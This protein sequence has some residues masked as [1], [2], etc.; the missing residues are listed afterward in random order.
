MEIPVGAAVFFCVDLSAAFFTGSAEEVFPAELAFAEDGVSE[1]TA[2]EIDVLLDTEL[3]KAASLLEVTVEGTAIK[4]RAEEEE[5][6]P[7]PKTY[8]ITERKT[9]TAVVITTA[10]THPR[11]L[12]PGFGDC[13]GVPKLLGGVALRKPKLLCEDLPIFSDFE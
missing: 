1:E 4:G 11:F 5:T 8:A 6:S 3:L 2:D 9:V 7:S 12:L 10:V 13:I